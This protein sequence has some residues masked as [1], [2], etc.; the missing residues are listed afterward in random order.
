[1]RPT[2]PSPV[3]FM[4]EIYDSTISVLIAQSVERLLSEMRRA[5]P[6]MAE[7]V[8]QWMC[9]LAGSAQPAQY[10]QHPLAYP[11]FLL[12]YW[13]EK[14]LQPTLDE[15]FQG[16]LIY[17]SMNIY[18][19]IRLMDNIMDSDGATEKHLLPAQ[20]FF[21]TQWQTTYQHYFA[22]EHPFWEYFQKIWFEAGDITLKDALLKD[23]DLQEF[24]LV[25]GRKVYAARIPC[26]AVCY[27]YDKLDALETWIPLYERLE[28]WHQMYN[29]VF[30]WLGDFQNQTPTY[31]LSEAQRR[32]N[33]DETIVSWVAREGF[34]W[35]SDL[36]RTWLVELQSIASTLNTTE[37]EDYLRF[38]ETLFIKHSDE[39]QTRLVQLTKLL[40]ALESK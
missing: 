20:G 11:I 12:P 23:I 3:K 14:S 18:Y 36:L 6:F 22:Y 10:F 1:L 2:I 28:R 31:F 7:R 39:I 27:R 40:G 16:D 5:A 30:G 24:M 19:F 21:H 33:P 32:K 25:S 29:D 17:S 8:E 34:A 26:A 15:S 37:L 35:A 38:R 13:L 4:S 9:D